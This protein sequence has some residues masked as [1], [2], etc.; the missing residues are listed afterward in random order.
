MTDYEQE[1]NNQM[2]LLYA[3]GGQW[4]AEQLAEQLIEYG[5]LEA[6]GMLTDSQN[7]LGLIRELVLSVESDPWR[8]QRFREV[9]VVGIVSLSDSERTRVANAVRELCKAE[10]PSLTN[11]LGLQLQEIK[12]T[13]ARYEKML[14]R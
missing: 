4:E 12:E 13:I 6:N 10:F 9:Y 7:R 3:L 5:K 1:L 11:K 2:D 8:L 14:S